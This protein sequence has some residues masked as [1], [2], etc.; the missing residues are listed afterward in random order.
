MRI[1][2]LALVVS[3]ALVAPAGVAAASQW[4]PELER[5]CGGGP[6]ACVG[7]FTPCRLRGF[8]PEVE[9]KFGPA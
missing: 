5:L 9:C 7:A 8:L 2:L 1:L 3:T 4:P 6:V